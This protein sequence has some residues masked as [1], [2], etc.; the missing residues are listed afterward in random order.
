MAAGAV[1][2]NVG[3]QVGLEGVF[4]RKSSGL[5]R[6]AG[7]LDVF[8]Y[9]LGLISVGIAFAF[10]QYYGPAQYPGSN[11]VVST[12]IAGGGMLFIALSFY[13]WSWTSSASAIASPS[14][15]GSASTRPRSP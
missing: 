12:F 10:N 9:N 7:A 4:V 8:S 1:G 14:R 15:T 2:S 11:V 3:Q 13:L 5:I 6:T